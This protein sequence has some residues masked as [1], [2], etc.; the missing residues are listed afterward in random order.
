M[1]H[2]I[3]FTCGVSLATAVAS[4]VQPSLSALVITGSALC[5]LGIWFSIFGE[6][7]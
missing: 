4:F 5:G 7:V 3:S 6:E 2:L 1:K